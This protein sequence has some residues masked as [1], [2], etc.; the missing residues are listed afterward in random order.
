MINSL[1]RSS[2]NVANMFFFAIRRNDRGSVQANLR[3][4]V[5]SRFGHRRTTG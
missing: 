1:A 5:P 2:N 4:P 3:E